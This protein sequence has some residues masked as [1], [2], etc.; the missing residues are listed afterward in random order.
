MQSRDSALDG[1]RG[2]AILL[3][4]FHHTGLN[5]SPA[6]LQLPWVQI[7]S[8]V[9]EHFWSG[10]DLF[11]VLSGYLITGILLNTRHSPNYYSAFYLRRAVRIF[12]L[13]YSVLIPLFI[14]V[15]LANSMGH[16]FGHF[17]LNPWI[18]TTAL[19]Y[20][21]NF[22]IS[23]P[24]THDQVPLLLTHFWSLCVEEQF[25]AFWPPLVRRL[26]TISLKTLIVFFIFM[27]L[28]FRIG[29]WILDF[30][31]AMGAFPLSRLD[32]LAC[33][34]GIAILCSESNGFRYWRPVAITTSLGFL[35]QMCM[36]T[37]YYFPRVL[38]RSLA[39]LAF[40]AILARIVTFPKSRIRTAIDR[41]WLRFFGK[42]SYALYI[43]HP[44]VLF[45]VAHRLPR[46]L[47]PPALD[48]FQFQ[49]LIVAI[50]TAA[51][52]L[53][54]RFIE[55]PALNLKRHRPFVYRNTLKE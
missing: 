14:F 27:S 44:F 11:F 38:P 50:S 16:R 20:T 45:V 21:L 12:P 39:I 36:D 5:L 37:G 24:G 49:I 19:T 17:D 10:V 22:L 26:S 40:A 31:H 13:Y 33:G 23:I 52:L 48:F 3:V 55:S 6:H 4:I 35:A 25:Y 8:R 51:A 30:R 42:Y 7:F 18:I 2:I 28:A 41:P 53:T 9:T 15:F 34:A 54:W 43:I 47:V 29:F 1:L 46:N 32:G